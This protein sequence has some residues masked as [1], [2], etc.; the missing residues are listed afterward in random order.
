MDKFLG[1]M[2]PTPDETSDNLPK[3]TPFGPVPPPA[4]SKY[5]GIYSSTGFDMI[6]VLARLANRP[7]PQINIGPIDFSCSFLVVD[8]RKYDFPIV[9][10]SPNFERLTGYSYKEILGR[11]CRFLQA[12]DGHVTLGSRR[13]YTD[14]SSVFHL[15]NG[16]LSGKEC[17]AP[18]IN[19]RKSGQPFMNLVSIIP[20]T[21]DSD[22]IAFFVGLQ[23]DLVEQPNAILERM[24]DGTYSVNYQ[25]IDIPA[26][27]PGSFFTGADLGDDFFRDQTTNPALPASEEAL[28]L[29]GSP[30][31]DDIETTKEL[32]YK[33]LLGQSADFI[34]V[35][36]LRGVFLY[37]SPSVREVL[38][39]EPEEIVGRSLSSLCHPSDIVPLMREL[40]D[41]SNHSNGVNLLYRI[42]RKHSGYMWLEC[43]GKL[44][45]DP[46]KVK[47]CFAL[48]AR[49][50][51]VFSLTRKKLQAAGGMVLNEL[52]SK[53]TLE[54]LWMFTSSS[55]SQLLGFTP[56]ELIGMSLYQ[57]VRAD[58]ATKLTRALNR[59]SKGITEP[60]QHYIQTKKGQYIEVES[61][62][63]PGQV[64]ANGNVLFLLSQIKEV[65]S[66][67]ILSIHT[68]DFAEAMSVDSSSSLVT[69][70]PIE[71][72]HQTKD[73]I[74]D[75]LE[76]VRSTSWQYEIHQLQV[77]NKKL[78]EQIES[79]S[80]TTG[81]N[82]KNGQR[83]RK[84]SQM[85]QQ[86]LICSQCH[87]TDS[88]EWRRGPLGPKTLCNAC[89]LRY[90]KQV[91][92]GKSTETPSEHASSEQ[93]LFEE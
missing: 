11:N 35:L 77:A 69:S 17:Q 48:V 75:E 86:N 90:A 88:P 60:I 82:G 65:G 85:Q 47:K 10:M 21:W 54:G 62:F 92:E 57:L 15:K 68:P 24:K 58:Q 79:Y 44:Y 6:G 59:A 18:L 28:K 19:Y 76:L 42:M 67:A 64:D 46:G 25:L 22:E 73:N 26:Y 32:W 4:S 5:S 84:K 50:R 13:R 91:A 36:S 30:L 3:A 14:N 12:P 56:S 83:K 38:E 81:H 51:P 29:L 7:N 2:N 34:H 66:E 41:N 78:R 40:K 87:R 71:V 63:Y 23:V 45:M 1:T 93:K 8:A 74:F 37:C 9:Y 31:P 33:M 49:E 52:W 16:L 61:V 20:I 80:L 39:Y 27:I 70:S 55:S 89:G 53:L 72:E 43:Y